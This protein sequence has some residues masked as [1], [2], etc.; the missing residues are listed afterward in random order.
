[1]TAETDPPEGAAISVALGHL[2]REVMRAAERYYLDVLRADHY[3]FLNRTGLEM[4]HDLAH[5]PE[6]SQ[7]DLQR[8]LGVE[9]ALITRYAKQMEAAGLIA[10]RV[11]PQ[12]NRLT[13]VSLTP[14][15]Q[16][17]ITEGMQLRASFETRLVAGL[18]ENEQQQL[19]RA[20][21]RLRANA[22]RMQQGVGNS[23][24]GGEG[25]EGGVRTP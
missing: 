1:M 10:R 15:G 21:Q 18:A 9:G 14:E 19:L 16:R 13:L 25:G 2:Y 7:R 12:D 8:S 20:M 11:D 24:E 22:R 3:P 6:I 23:G 17:L 5:H 4:L